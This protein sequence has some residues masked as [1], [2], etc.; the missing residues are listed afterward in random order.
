MGLAV[1]N[2]RDFIACLLEAVKKDALDTTTEGMPIFNFESLRRAAVRIVELNLA[3]A[4][5]NTWID[6]RAP[7]FQHEPQTVFTRRA[8][9]PSGRTRIPRPAAPARVGR[10]CVDVA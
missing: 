2:Q 8:V 9:H 4:A 6:A 1:I 10:H 7:A 3:P 5:R